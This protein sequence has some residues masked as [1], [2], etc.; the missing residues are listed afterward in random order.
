MAGLDEL[1]LPP[2]DLG[3]PGLVI[4]AGSSRDAMDA[5]LRRAAEVTVPAAIGSRLTPELPS[6]RGQPALARA[7]AAVEMIRD[8]VPSEEALRLTGLLE[9]EF[10][11]VAAAANRIADR[12]ER[13]DMER[14]RAALR[15][16][17]EAT[18]ESLDATATGRVPEATVPRVLERTESL[19]EPTVSE[20]T[21]EMTARTVAAEPTVT[22]PMAARV[23]AEA[24]PVA[25]AVAEE[26]APVAKVTEEAAV[27]AP[28]TLRPEILKAR[29]EFEDAQA[30]LTELG[31]RPA[32]PSSEKRAFGVKGR[33]GAAPEDVARWDAQRKASVQ[34]PAKHKR[35]SEQRSAAAE[36]LKKSD[37]VWARAHSGLGYDDNLDLLEAELN[38]ATDANRAEAQT[39][40]SDAQQA[41]E[42]YRREMSVAAPATPSGITPPVSA[43]VAA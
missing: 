8:E 36:V 21:M 35:L 3:V 15:A 20:P 28:A 5:V 1:P 4:A 10:A 37:P 11:R 22:E 12:G 31:P 29:R 41:V 32:A 19:Y 42:Q 9:E 23:T 26:A 17:T 7:V 30:R 16:E 34:W 14:L 6:L 27:A 39:R 2:E 40:L 38:L 24:A 13:A 18:L 43:P 33:E 25:E